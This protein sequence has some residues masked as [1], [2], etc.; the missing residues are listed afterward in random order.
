[1]ARLNGV[2]T[3]TGPPDPPR[4]RP[5]RLEHRC[6]AANRPI[7][8]CACAGSRPAARVR[9][10][11]AARRRCR[12]CARC[13]SRASSG[14]WNWRRANSSAVQAKM[15]SN[16]ASRLST[17][18]GAAAPARRAA[19]CCGSR[20]RPD[21]AAQP[22]PDEVDVAKVER[23][24]QIEIA[25]SNVPHAQHPVRNLPRPKPDVPVPAPAS[26]AERIEQRVPRRARGVVQEENGR[27]SAGLAAGE[28]R[29]RDLDL[30][31]SHR[32]PHAALPD[33][34]FPRSVVGAWL[35]ST[36]HWTRQGEQSLLTRGCQV[37]SCG[38]PALLSGTGT[39]CASCGLWR[40]GLSSGT[41]DNAQ[42]RGPVPAISQGLAVVGVAALVLA[43]SR[44]RRRL[45][46]PQRHHC[47]AVRSRGHVQ[48]PRAP[49][50]RQ[51]RAALRQ[52]LHRRESARRQLGDRR[53]R[54]GAGAGRRLH[55]HG[56]DQLD[57]GDQCQPAQ[58]PSV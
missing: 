34:A 46:E 14:L 36:R 17:P 57:H 9:C 37:A 50:R 47:R 48:H 19:C 55:A 2:C 4:P 6:G 31:L 24:E 5:A 18:A 26:D 13:Q 30:G 51:A 10:G 41:G 33:G 44:A 7:A 25:E 38:E 43:G 58:E 16:G 23:V 11:S 20:S 22:V 15:S 27:P 49:D 12:A 28:R 42:A 52:I 35:A 53:G 40:R 56:R 45:P 21:P 32:P 3:R 1:M 54:G 8:D 29:S 39:T